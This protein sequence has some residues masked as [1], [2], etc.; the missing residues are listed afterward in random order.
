MNV[1]I[2]YVV[3]VRLSG[4][5]ILEYQKVGRYGPDRNHTDLFFDY[6]VGIRQTRQ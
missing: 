6:L 2:F 5:I 3:S 4:K 1:W